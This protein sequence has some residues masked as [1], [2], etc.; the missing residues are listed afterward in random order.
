MPAPTNISATT[1]TDLVSLPASV[2][3]N[4]HDSGT[5]YT[6]WYRFT[7]PSD[8][9]LGI[10]GFGDLVGYSPILNI[11]TGPESAPV[12]TDVFGADNVPAQI[13]ITGGTEY[14]F[15]FV[16]NSTTVS[17]AVLLIEA[18][19]F[20]QQS[21]SSGSIFIND[22]T[23][24]FPAVFLDSTTGNPIRFVDCIAGEN[25]NILLDGTTLLSEASSGDVVLYDSQF[26]EIARIS[27]PFSGS[28]LEPYVGTNKSNGFYVGYPGTGGTTSKVA[29]VSNAG[30]VGSTW[31]LGVTG[32]KGLNPNDAETIL[33]YGSNT[34]SNASIKRWD[35]I[36]DVALSD[37]VVEGATEIYGRDLLV[38]D[39]DTII[40]FFKLAASS[41]AARRYDTSGN[42]LNTYT[43]SGSTATNDNRITL[44]LNDTTH[45]WMWIKIA[46]GISRFDRVVTSSGSI[47]LTFTA[48]QYEAGLYQAAATTSPLARFGHSES[49]PFLITST[50]SSGRNTTSGLYTLTTTGTTT[51]STT[52]DSVLN[53]A[54]T[55]VQVQIVWFAESGDII[56]K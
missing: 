31:D 7:P 56:D 49:C 18:E 55:Q 45:F 27:N 44:D 9:M 16:R 12:L 2:S 28:Y 40:G 10:W 3:Q 47:D 32:L 33:Y 21:A 23:D 5:T 39:D 35:L 14:F 20:S 43:V 42:L 36:N 19:Q 46:G 48:V 13:M 51:G 41:F 25:G 1:A 26:N 24:G 38:L 8:M 4:V 6:V 22:D 29:F 30:V 54:G 11:Y 34:G 15:E 52:I 50:T 37:L 17:P 53:T